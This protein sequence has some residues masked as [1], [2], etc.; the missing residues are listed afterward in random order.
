[1]SRHPFKHLVIFLILLLLATSTAAR[2]GQNSRHSRRGQLKKRQVHKPKENS[3]AV[4]D[5]CASGGD[6][7]GCSI[8][9]AAAEPETYHCEFGLRDVICAGCSGGRLI[10]APPLRYPSL[11]RAARY[12]GRTAQQGH[13]TASGMKNHYCVKL[14]RAHDF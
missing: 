12:I 10:S 11:A 5:D 2:D 13:A 7:E 9:M 1:M 4:K 14:N 6:T 3:Q 8:N